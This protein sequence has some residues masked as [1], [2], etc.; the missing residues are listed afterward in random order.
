MTDTPANAKISALLDE[1]RGGNA[2]AQTELVALIY[3]QLR[4]IAQHYLRSERVGHTLQPTAL[5]H[6]TYAR[7]FGSQRTD[8]KNR[9]H[10]FAAVATEMRRIL[11]D[12]ARARN[13][14]KR[15]G[16]QVALS[17]AD[18][19]DLGVAPDQDLVAL[20][21][22]LRRLETLDARAARVVELRFFT[23]LNEQEAAEA[24][25]ISVSTLKR[26]WEYARAWLFS[27][28]K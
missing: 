22:A 14:Q 27:E 11:V 3:P 8:W 15:P 6:E 16:K 26:D 17:L 13:A 10:F 24:L 2:Q 28:L 18:I 21:E 25:G 9:A 1:L 19:K 23:G 20:D 5:V 7:L 4:E 12:Y